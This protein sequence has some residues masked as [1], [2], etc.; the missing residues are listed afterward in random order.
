MAT[1]QPKAAPKAAPK[2]TKQAPAPVA[3]APVAPAPTVALRGGPAVQQVALTGKPYRSAAA[4]N[5]AW[6]Q[7]VQQAA[8]AGPAPVAALLA[9]GVPAHFVGYT[10][11]RGY[12]VAA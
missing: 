9:A 2:A 12:L 7:Q 4:H 8:A 3:P 10:M 1:K 6:W 5:T 11:R